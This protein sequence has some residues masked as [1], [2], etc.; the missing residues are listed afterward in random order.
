MS[1]Y[2]ELQSVLQEKSVIT[3]VE[4]KNNRIYFKVD[5]R[6]FSTFSNNVYH[7]KHPLFK[8][9]VSDIWAARH[10]TAEGIE[11]DE[12]NAEKFN[13]D[14]D[15]WIK[16]KNSLYKLIFIKAIEILA[17][18]GEEA[19]IKYVEYH[20][21]ITEEGNNCRKLLKLLEEK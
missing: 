7:E 17:T 10:N 5:G 2:L 9:P 1:D 12:K 15:L 21:F 11:E 13:E 14:I 3:D 6:L 19:F 4:S 20:F 18:K 8:H 16:H